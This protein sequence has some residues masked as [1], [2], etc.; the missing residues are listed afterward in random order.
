MLKFQK[1]I[2]SGKSISIFS[3]EEHPM[4]GIH[5]LPALLAGL[6]YPPFPVLA[7]RL[8]GNSGLGSV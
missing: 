7:P 5:H 8:D 2:P 4:P 3:G 1:K 6:P